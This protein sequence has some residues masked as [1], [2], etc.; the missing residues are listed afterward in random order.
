MSKIGS[1]ELVIPDVLQ[2]AP[3][4]ILPPLSFET[5]TELREAGWSRVGL[6]VPLI[7]H[8]GRLLIL[9][10]NKSDKADEGMLGPLGETSKEALPVI[11][12]PLETLE[13]GLREELGV[14][15]P[16]HLGIKMRAESG[17]FTHAW[18]RG[19]NYP[20]E[21]ACAISPA[22]YV[23]ELA[24]SALLSRKHGNEEICG[25]AVMTPEEVLD[26]AEHRL[27]PGMPDW[28]TKLCES[29]FMHWPHESESRILD[30]SSVFSA[31]LVDLDLQQVGA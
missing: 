13:R 23:P 29:G 31:G 7:T 26:T 1:P 3:G 10:H 30:F 21:Y 27:R 5:V 19:V 12:Q 9:K 20:G 4:L 24:E 18:P 15:E 2:P 14:K 6:L 25:L 8:A 11:E 17:W 16:A 22:V 28:I